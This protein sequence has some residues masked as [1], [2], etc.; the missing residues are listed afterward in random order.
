[1]KYLKLHIFTILTLIIGSNSSFG[2]KTTV[3]GKIIDAL[4]CEHL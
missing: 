1:M 2:Q 4:L 3:T